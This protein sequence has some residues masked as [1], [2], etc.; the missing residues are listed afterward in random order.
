MVAGRV[1]EDSVLIPCAGLHA[2]ILVNCA[3]DLQLAVMDRYHCAGSTHVNGEKNGSA[4][5]EMG[6]KHGSATAKKSYFPT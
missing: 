1:D 5:A 4:T 3:Q 2:D 6:H